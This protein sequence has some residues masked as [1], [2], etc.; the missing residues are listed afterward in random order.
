MNFLFWLFWAV[1][2]IIFLV[3]LYETFAVRS[4]RGLLLPA[5]LMVA[6]LVLS[7]WLRS[8]SPRLAFGLAAAPAGLALL[9]GLFFILGS[10]GRS[11]WQ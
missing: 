8:S 7:F 2:L 9:F 11:N 10:M 1:D 6:L 3:C 4:N 5:L